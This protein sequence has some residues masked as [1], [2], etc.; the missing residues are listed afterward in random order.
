MQDMLAERLADLQRLRECVAKATENRESAK[1]A[2]TAGISAARAHM[3]RLRAELAALKR[4]AATAG[5]TGATEEI[6]ASA[7]Q[8]IISYGRVVLV[9]GVPP[10]TY[11][12]QYCRD[13]DREPESLDLGI[14]PVDFSAAVPVDDSMVCLETREGVDGPEYKIAFTK[15]DDQKNQ[16]YKLEV[17]NVWDT[18]INELWANALAQLRA[19]SAMTEESFCVLDADPLRL[20]GIAD[21]STQRLVQPTLGHGLQQVSGAPAAVYAAA[22]AAAASGSPPRE[23]TASLALLDDQR[24]KAEKSRMDLRTLRH[25]MGRWRHQAETLEASLPDEEAELQRLQS[26]LKHTTDILESTRGAYVQRAAEAQEA[27]K[28]ALKRSA[29]AVL[30]NIVPLHNGGHGGVE[31][32]AERGI[33][34]QMEQ[35]G[36]ELNAHQQLLVG[37]MSSQQHLIHRL[38][39][40]LLT[41]E[42]ELDQKTK[43]VAKETSRNDRL[44]AR[45]RK[46]N[47]RLVA[48]AI[49]AR[50]KVDAV[51]AT[52]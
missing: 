24:D 10:P 38:E 43:L 17:D 1:R 25:E 4:A 29:S 5:T 36:D 27:A 12:F 39:A 28:P 22:D 49:G 2:C 30:K 21:K 19:D 26:E 51:A 20:F 11:Q 7:A 14:V 6:Q 32:F 18:N 3:M 37:D 35:R 23:A 40:A 47:E 52:A 9:E 31:A 45:V 50:S 41:Q 16:I 48:V 8:T 13:P 34:G 46:N 33:R 44:K 15:H 42:Q